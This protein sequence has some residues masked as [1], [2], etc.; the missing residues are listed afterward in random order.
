M[1]THSREVD[2]SLDSALDI[3][4][5]PD[6]QHDAVQ[7]LETCKM[8]VYSSEMH[9]EV[10]QELNIPILVG[11][12][13]HYIQRVGGRSFGDQAWL[14]V[15]QRC[16]AYVCGSA[17]CF[18]ACLKYCIIRKAEQRRGDRTGVCAQI[19]F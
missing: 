16:W 15:L 13:K 2:E 6:M 18:C 12:I 9:V 17:L 7:S 11:I 5:G 10:A 3:K 1:I 19:I 14:L 4:Q 8:I